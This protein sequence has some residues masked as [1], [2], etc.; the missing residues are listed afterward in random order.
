[1]YPFSPKENKKIQFLRFQYFHNLYT[2]ITREPQVQSLSTW[3]LLESLSHIPEQSAGKSNVLLLRFLRYCYSMVGR[4]SHQPSGVQGVKGL[5]RNITLKSQFF[6]YFIKTFVLVQ[7]QSPEMFCRCS[8]TGVFLR[9]SRIFLKTFFTE[10]TR[11]LYLLILFLV[12]F[13]AIINTTCFS[14]PFDKGILKNSCTIHFLCQCWHT[15]P[16]DQNRNWR[17]TLRL[18]NVEGKSLWETF[19]KESNP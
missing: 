11:G 1:M 13:I 15:S 5:K 14:S 7:K 8:G 9:I 18:E 17:K 12:V 4:Y 10:N 2:S 3:I 6:R 19:Q 16:L